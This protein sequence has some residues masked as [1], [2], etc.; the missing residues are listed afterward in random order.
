[1]PNAVIEKQWYLDTYKFGA[2]SRAGAPPI[3]L[4]GPW[5]ADDGKLPPWKGDYHHDLNTE[6]SYWP[7]YSGNRLEEGRNFLDW[8]WDTR[9][10]CRD[11]TRRFF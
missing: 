8:L 4:Q 6:L 7:C 3:T 1:M 10:A 9:A 2:A 11:W 5:T